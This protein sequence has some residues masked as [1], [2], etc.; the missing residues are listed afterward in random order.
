[1]RESQQVLDR[2]SNGKSNL[3]ESQN[4][5]G[6]LSNVKTNGGRISRPS[7]GTA[8]WLL[9]QISPSNFI[10]YNTILLWLL[11]AARG[12]EVLCSCYITW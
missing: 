12:V 6:R 4:I 3:R 1:M 11:V 10:V 2:V 5:C 7:Y 9:Q 8:K